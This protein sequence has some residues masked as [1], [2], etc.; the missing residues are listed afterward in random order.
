MMKVADYADLEVGREFLASRT[1]S[2]WRRYP[3]D[4][5]PSW[6]AEMDFLPPE[7]LQDAIMRLA[8]KRDYGYARRPLMP[9]ERQVGAAFA[10]RMAE[11]FGW[12]IEET[13]T[14]AV[15]DLLQGTIAAILAF[16]E[17]GEHVAVHTP[18]YG[19][20]REAIEESGRRMVDVPMLETAAGFVPDMDALRNAPA[21]TR[22]LILCNP[23]NPTGRVFTRAE[24]EEIASI[25]V[26]RDMI[27]FSDEVHADFVY[28][29]RTHIPIASLSQEVAARTITANSPGKSFNIA[30]LR[31]GV[32]HFGTP[33][34]RDR[35]FARVPRLLLGR[36]SVVSIDAAVAAWTV[37]QPWLDRIMALLDRNRR[38]VVDTIAERMPKLKLYMPE[39]SFLA[40]IDCR[41]LGWDRPAASV[42]L[43]DAGIA[44]SSGESFCARHDGFVRLNFGAS[45]EV[46]RDKLARME[47][48]VNAR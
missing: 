32:M 10:D 29:G 14:Q 40:W 17:P 11:R 46:L 30:G 26:D 39:A 1:G 37:C 28:G 4:V 41:A 23:Q 31:C 33:A 34:L 12:K 2:K 9:A 8:G 35:F 16:S 42:F 43:E 48:L 15:T 36:P 13:S 44:F 21:D 27:V 18:C 47:K 45:E 3:A 19:P 20:F 38:L 5:I 22:L 24:L 25:A 7:D 6:I